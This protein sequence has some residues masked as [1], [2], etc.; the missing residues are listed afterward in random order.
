MAGYCTGGTYTSVDI[1][2][3]IL[4]FHVCG[5]LSNLRQQ[6]QNLC[7]K[8]DYE[9]KIKLAQIVRKH[10]SLNR[11]VNTIEKEFNGMLL[12]QMLGCSIQL[13][14]TCFQTT[15]VLK[16]GNTMVFIQ[17]FFYG[18]YLIYIL[19]QIYL[20]CYIGEKLISESIGIVDAVY[21]CQWYH[22]SPNE[23]KSLMFIM[24]RAR[25]PLHITAG[26]FCSFSHKLFGNILRTSMSYL[27]MLHA[28]NVVNAE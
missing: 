14:V 6:L 13:C 19:L 3:V 23:S 18:F 9:F 4:V 1:F 25:I 17:M 11:F 28:M 26:K 15:L 22:F 8:N 16:D 27:S 20:Y 7:P 24:L 12:L 5:Q 2:V 10:D 21:E